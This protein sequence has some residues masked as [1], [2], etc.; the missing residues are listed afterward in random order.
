MD[1]PR[2]VQAIMK[3]DD[4]TLISEFCGNNYIR[5]FAQYL[6]INCPETTF[7]DYGCSFYYDKHMN[8]NIIFT[9]IIEHLNFSS[10]KENGLII[11]IMITKIETFCD[12]II[13]I[14]V[15]TII[16]DKI[17]RTFSC[18]FNKCNYEIIIDGINNDEFL[19]Y[20]QNFDTTKI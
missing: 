17:H 4:T 12:D 11:T 3:N 13:V 14:H 15:N 8:K 7:T 16:R 20:L 6:K 19:M 5:K 9:P 1:I 10:K 2:H 18:V